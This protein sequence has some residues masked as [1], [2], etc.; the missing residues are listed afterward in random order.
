MHNV[1]LNQTEL[2]N[3]LEELVYKVFLKA[4]KPMQFCII[5]EQ[6]VHLIF[7]FSFC[8]PLMTKGTPS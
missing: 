2:R 1:A 5:T 8:P 3:L 6:I 7:M 4:L